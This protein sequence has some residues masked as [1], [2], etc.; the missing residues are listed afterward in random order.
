MLSKEMEQI[1]KSV[2][3]VSIQA[4]NRKRKIC[5]FPVKNYEN[6]DTSSASQHVLMAKVL[7][8]D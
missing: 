3:W 5:V 4:K 6:K 1:C 7:I 8:K 2:S